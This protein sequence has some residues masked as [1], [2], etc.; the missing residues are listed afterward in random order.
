MG[1]DDTAKMQTVTGAD[2]SALECDLNA[3]EMTPS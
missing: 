2:A 3:A 1:R